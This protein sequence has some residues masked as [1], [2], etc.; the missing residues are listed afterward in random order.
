MPK[1]DVL[2]YVDIYLCLPLHILSQVFSILVHV[3]MFL[4]GLR[5][6]T[7]LSITCRRSLGTPSSCRCFC[8]LAMSYLPKSSWTG[9]PIR[10]NVL[11]STRD[12]RQKQHHLAG[13]GKSPR[14]LAPS[15][16]E[17][18]SCP[19]CLAEMSF[20]P[21]SLL[22]ISHVSANQFAIT[23]G[24]VASHLSEQLPWIPL[25]SEAL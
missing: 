9:L 7:C 5:A 11:V 20:F 6:V 21:P 12:A 15:F 16:L 13:K 8:P 14:R 4:Q 22:F 25:I 10:A 2:L 1:I 3:C 18:V 24:K 19:T 23:A 17:I